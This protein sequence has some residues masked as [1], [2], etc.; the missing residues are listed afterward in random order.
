MPC[1]LRNEIIASTRPAEKDKSWRGHR[2][3]LNPFDRLKIAIARTRLTSTKLASGTEHPLES[4]I[5]AKVAAEARKSP[6]LRHITGRPRPEQVDRVMLRQYQL[7]KVRRMI[8][9][10]GENSYFY[11]ARWKE[12]GIK[13]SD[14]RTFD[15]LCKIPLTEPKELAEVPLEFLCVSQT[16]VMRAFTTSGTSGTRK[17]LFYSRDDILNIVD[18]IAVA[19]KNAGMN[20]N[21]TLQ[22]MFPT[23]AA[24]DPGLMLEGACKVAGLKAINAS[25]TDI[26][27]QLN[28]MRQNRTSMMIGL[29]SFI[30]RITV[31]AR[32]KLD[33]RSFGIKAIILSAEPLPE[34]MRREI[35]AA[36][37]CKALS[38]YGMTEMGL[39]TT[40]ECTA[41]DGMH[42]NE[43]DF[44][45][46]VIDPDTGKH[47]A[48]REEG[49]L[50][51]T[52]LSFEGSPL[53]RY[54][55]YDISATIEPPCGCGFGAVGKIAKIRGRLDMQ[56]K[57]GF[58]EKVYPLLFDEAILGVKDS[59][60][61]QVTIDRPNYKDRLHFKVEFAG[62]PVQGK[63]ALLKAILAIA[64]I[65]SGLEN[66]LLDPPE[67]EVVL[68]DQ[69]GWVPKTRA[70]IDNRR[71]YD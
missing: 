61:Y 1:P 32:E 62:E 28:I 56:T 10:T 8:E 51:W 46:E 30:Y 13:A 7:H 11:K 14:I 55:S 60:G 69:K 18:S 31:L 19:L 58:G 38:Q 66:D 27:E 59:L 65:K 63:E 53:L 52:S 39:A 12:F 23:V 34:A 36:W 22:I 5:L 33:L 29:T 9:Y 41:Q 6:E 3:S 25:T 43:A 57:I 4:W 54:R 47:C 42:V 70:I 15:D 37:G 20:E 2:L 64:E 26:E 48:D 67:V 16:K 45:P 35:E 21:D 17:R 71:Q 68:P 44:L 50:I 24:W 40:I 49:E